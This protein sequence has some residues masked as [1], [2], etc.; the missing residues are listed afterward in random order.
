MYRFRSMAL[1]LPVTG[2]PTR[3][4]GA[5]A[6]E[7]HAVAPAGSAPVDLARTSGFEDPEANARR[8]EALA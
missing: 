2:I 4:A 5:P 6:L 1:T 8:G 7:L 3:P